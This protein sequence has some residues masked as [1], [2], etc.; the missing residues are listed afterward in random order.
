[1]ESISN[2]GFEVILG[3]QFVAG[4]NGKGKE[5][6]IRVLEQNAMAATIVQQLLH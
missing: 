3:D 1:L 5:M 4:S 2:C 6:E